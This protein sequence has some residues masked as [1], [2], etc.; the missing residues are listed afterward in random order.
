[1]N[2]VSVTASARRAA[3]DAL[4]QPDPQRKAALALALRAALGDG[5]LHIDPAEQVAQP[6]AALPGRPARPE[7]IAAQRLLRRNP[8]DRKGHVALI[9]ALAHIEFNA[10]NLALDAVWRFAGLPAEFYGDWLR[11]AAEEAEHFTLLRQHLLSLGADYGDI[12][13]HD[14]LWEM[15]EKTAGDVLARM[16]LVPRTLEARGLDVNPAIRAKLAAVG[17]ARGAAILDR[18]LADEIGHVAIGNR[19]YR[20]ACAQHGRDA[21]TAG[22]ELGA[23][24]GAP[25]LK[26]PFNRQA[27]LRAGFSAAELD[28]LERS[29]AAATAML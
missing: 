20:W 16:A 3:L 15:A 25:R 27:R 2:D 11:V 26:A 22:D 29:A 10:I 13:A 1:M 6:T 21:L 18:I 28:A 9:H 17:D 14:G 8:H 12:P 5:R 4:L 23:A 7:L 24:Y 19:W